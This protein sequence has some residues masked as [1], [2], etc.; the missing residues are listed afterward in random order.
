MPGTQVVGI[1]AFGRLAG[2]FPEVVEVPFGSL[3]AVVV[4]A[5]GGFRAVLVATP[6]GVVAVGELFGRSILVCVV[7]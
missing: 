5:W 1:V 4:V 3:V 7:A 2:S 6:R